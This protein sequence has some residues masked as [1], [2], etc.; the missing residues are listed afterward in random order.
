MNNIELYINKQL[1]D[2]QSPEK[3]GIRLNRV[4]ITP[5]ELNTQDA[6]YSY[7]ITIPSTRVN[8][9]IFGYA[10][11]EE[12]KNKFNHLYSAQLYIDS[13]RIFEGQL[14]LSEIE[15]DGNY[16][17]N[18]VVP[19]MKTIKDIFGDKKM[20]EITDEWQLDLT[21]PLNDGKPYSLAEMLNAFNTHPGTPDCIF[22]LVLYGL[23]PKIPKNEK[24]E[25]TDKAVWDKYVRLGVQEFPPSM[26]CLKTIRMVF[27]KSKDANGRPYSIG[28]N[29]FDD[30]RLTNLY[31]SYQNPVDYQQEWNWGHLGKIAMKGHWSNFRKNADNTHSHERYYY[32]NDDGGRWNNYFINNLFRSSM[33]VIDTFEDASA[34]VVRYTTDDNEKNAKCQNIH[35]TIPRSGLYKISLDATLTVRTDLQNYSFDNLTYIGQ[36]NNVYG[37]DNGNKINNFSN[38]RYELKL[39]RDFGEG[40]FGIPDLKFDGGLYRDNLPQDN[41]P[42]KTRYFPL[43]GGYNQLNG[44]FTGNCVQMIDPLQNA[45]IVSGFR[46]GEYGKTMELGSLYYDDPSMYP[47]PLE[48]TLKAPDKYKYCRIMAIK[49]G[50]SWDTKFSQKNKI[51]SAIHSPGYSKIVGTDPEKEDNEIGDTNNASDL[52]KVEL[53]GVTNSITNT[54]NLKGEGKLNQIV[55][56]EKGEHLTLVGVTS[57]GHYKNTEGWM[58]HDIDFSLSIEP[59]KTQPEWITID[60][61]GTGRAGMNWNDAS[62]F[63][64]N[65]INLFRFLPSEQ[66]IDEWLDNFC[67]AFNLQL[68]QVEAGKFEL[69]VKQARNG[70][71]LSS[72]LDLDNKASIRGR[73]NQPL[74]LPSAFQ[75]GFKINQDEEGYTKADPD[76]K[77]GG[78]SFATGN[79]DGSVVTQ[80]SNFSYNWFKNSIRRTVV[81]TTAEGQE[82]TNDTLLLLPVVTHKEVWASDSPKDYAEMMKKTYTNYAQR[83]WY[84]GTGM[85]NVGKVWENQASDLLLPQICNHID[86]PTTR[87][88]LN[89]TN[90][91]Y[92]IL[93]SYF[94]IIATDNSNYTFVE[95]YLSPDEYEQLDGSKLVKLNGDLYYISAIEG[96]DPLGHNKT[97]L[98][99]IRRVT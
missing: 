28:G 55:W 53:E 24:A 58:I 50:W 44:E 61:K 86:T 37:G 87:L 88:N 3:L 45:K 9:A 93:T 39:L 70:V 52:F 7:S 42:L 19:A 76:N 21:N 69:N 71:Q 15:A 81:D 78:G 82:V 41:T 67:K 5:S 68:T 8:D 11:V 6:Q 57:S 66:K 48:Y 80:T 91:A 14:K 29:A 18:L 22:P 96:Y 38:S 79:I 89:Y 13:I 84:K 54:D 43:P 25:Y 17:G 23:F 49:H 77:D 99:L 36:E 72:P 94:N 35:L 92:T 73:T 34:N 27:E 2:I 4:L 65:Y 30:N 85:Y 32:R 16:K 1:C 59:F 56:L 20:T 60:N 75:L 33:T 95:C 26:N 46:W 51:Y 12:V 62:D 74:G 31:M 97:K 10:N 98:R 90:E 40:D 63:K 83:F 64:T 47:N